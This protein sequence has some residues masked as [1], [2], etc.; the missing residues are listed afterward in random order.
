MYFSV[1]MKNQSS[2]VRNR[3]EQL[4]DF[5]EGSMR[6]MSELT[7]Q[8]YINTIETL[9]RELVSSWNQDHRVDALKIAIQVLIYICL[10]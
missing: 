5:E 9:N 1:V 10:S 4:D 3:L 2:V 8:E 6:E 7:Q